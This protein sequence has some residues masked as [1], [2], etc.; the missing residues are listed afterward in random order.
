VRVIRT[1]ITELGRDP[2]F[3]TA[4]FS[5][6][7]STVVLVTP[8]GLLIVLEE[9]AAVKRCLGF[10]GG[11]LK[12]G[13]DPLE[14]AI[15]EWQEEIN[16]TLSKSAEIDIVYHTNSKG[17]NIIFVLKVQ[18][19]SHGQIR[20]PQNTLHYELVP[21]DFVVSGRDKYFHI[22][23]HALH[24]CVNAKQARK[25]ALEFLK[26]GWLHPESINNLPRAAIVHIA[27]LIRN[28]ICKGCDV[29]ARLR[30]CTYNGI[31][32]IENVVL[33]GCGH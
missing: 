18:N 3:Q 10:V 8:E 5:A 11:S 31:K 9:K 26:I 14:G 20:L 33:N 22:K 1:K 32:A 24:V 12:A 19:F 29:R 7:S 27:R 2:T 25:S 13:E 23:N 16:Y 4:W 21:W 17:S 6:V 28:N 30:Q 15:R